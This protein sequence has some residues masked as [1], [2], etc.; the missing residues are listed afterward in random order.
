MSEKPST[1]VPRLILLVFLLGLIII[2]Y[3]VYRTEE[4]A[5]SWTLG[6]FVLI[7][8]SAVTLFSYEGFRTYY[9]TSYGVAAVSNALDSVFDELDQAHARARKRAAKQDGAAAGGFTELQQSQIMEPSAAAAVVPAPMP[10]PTADPGPYPIPSA[11]PS[12]GPYSIPS[13]VPGPREPVKWSA[14]RPEIPKEEAAGAEGPEDEVKPTTLPPE[15]EVK[16]EEKPP[17]EKPVVVKE[18][19]KEGIAVLSEDELED[20]S[21]FQQIIDQNY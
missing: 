15:E 3:G 11:I 16:K 18:A 4:I 8:V 14:I 1:L 21:S 6:G 17:E 13:P 20:D 12:S 10:T 9:K 5:T 19:E 2:G 7:V